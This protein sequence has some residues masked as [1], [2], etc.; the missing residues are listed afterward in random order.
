MD[1]FDEK[2]TEGEKKTVQFY[3]SIHK[4][5]HPFKENVV[6][7]KKSIEELNTKVRLLENNLKLKDLKF[8]EL[9]ELIINSNKVVKADVIERCQNNINVLEGF[10]AK[11]QTCHNQVIEAKAI[12][13]GT[14]AT[15]EATERRL[16]R[17]ENQMRTLQEQLTIIRETELD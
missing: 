14:K 6:A 3:K 17:F 2:Q 10:H 9:E 11:M 12:C 4:E 7:H 8:K 16:R 15:L 1:T 5:M 13:V